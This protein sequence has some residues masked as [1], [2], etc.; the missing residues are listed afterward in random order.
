MTKCSE[1]YG[2]NQIKWFDEYK[3]TLHNFM[4]VHMLVRFISNHAME[5]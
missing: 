2:S 4:Q 3:F 1:L 5:L